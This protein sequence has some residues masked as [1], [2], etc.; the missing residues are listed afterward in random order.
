VAQAEAKSMRE[1]KRDIEA[2]IASDNEMTV[3]NG[4]GTP[5]G[6]RGLGK[7]IQSTAQATN[8]FLLI[9]APHPVR[10]LIRRSVSPRL[11][12]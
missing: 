9:I 1:I 11:T 7:W 2:T 10:S 4:A 8:Q 12:R 6:M 5:Y 3:E